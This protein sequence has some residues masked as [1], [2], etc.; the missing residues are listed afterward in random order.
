MVAPNTSTPFL[1]SFLL[2][3]LG[4][5][6]TADDEGMKLISSPPSALNFTFEEFPACA[7]GC[8]EERRCPNDA[9]L[10]PSFATDTLVWGTMGTRLTLA[11]LR[12][13]ASRVRVYC[14]STRI[15][16]CPGRDRGSNLVSSVNRHVK[17]RD[18]MNGK[19]ILT[20]S[21]RT[22]IAT[23]AFRAV[24]VTIGRRPVTFIF[25]FLHSGLG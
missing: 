25:L 15:F 2:A 16:F 1:E 13:F 22:I 19:A 4:A 12:R 3:G 21:I 9:F 23:L 11:P 8:R 6:S 20:T 24:A 7:L 10:S 17:Q 14:C 5:S 18:K